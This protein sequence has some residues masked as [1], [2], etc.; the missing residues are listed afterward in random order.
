MGLMMAG[1]RLSEM[2]RENASGF[3]QPT[4]EGAS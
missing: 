2:R 1:D 3:L 4:G